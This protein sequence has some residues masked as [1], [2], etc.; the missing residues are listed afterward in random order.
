MC[1]T[2]GINPEC[3]E[4]IPHL[5]SVLSSISTDSVQER[6]KV[7]PVVVK[8]GHIYINILKHTT[9][10]AILLILDLHCMWLVSALEISIN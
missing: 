3:N 1:E 5:T 9:Y 10:V 8:V 7:L 4:I 6:N 2:R